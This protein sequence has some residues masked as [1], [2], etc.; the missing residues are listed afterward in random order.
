M[1]GQIDISKMS[2]GQVFQLFEG[3]WCVRLDGTSYKNCGREEDA[4]RYSAEVLAKPRCNECGTPR[5]DEY[6][7]SVKKEI[8][9]RQLC[10]F[11]NFWTNIFYDKENHV[12]IDGRCYQILPDEPSNH[13]WYSG[14]GGQ[15]FSIEFPDGRTVITHNLW[16]QGTIPDHFK[17]RFPNTA[18]FT[19]G[20]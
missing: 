15:E 19:K 11:C 9:T 18:K 20:Q 13:R 6:M 7:D 5:Y 2:F 1:F 12:F 4:N 14:F 8:Q 3:H 16:H 17:D 10:F